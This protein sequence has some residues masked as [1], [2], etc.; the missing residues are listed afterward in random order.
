MNN[1]HLTLSVYATPPLKRGICRND[2]GDF[3]TQAF[4]DAFAASTLALA[5][6]QACNKI[7]LPCWRPLLKGKRLGG[8]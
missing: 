4:K 1:D 2:A 5:S 3:Q 8:E 7:C 6:L